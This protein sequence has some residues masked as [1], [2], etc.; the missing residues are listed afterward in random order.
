M[1]GD[2]I[3][4][5]ITD[6]YKTGYDIAS[7]L[8]VGTGAAR[9]IVRAFGFLG[10]NSYRAIVDNFSSGTVTVMVTIQVYFVRLV[11]S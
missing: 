1:A 7:M 6:V 8:V 5:T 10:N 9:A 2:E 4:V 3:G 11:K